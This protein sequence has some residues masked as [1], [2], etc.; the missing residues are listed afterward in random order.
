MKGGGQIPSPRR[1]K[2]KERR[3]IEIKNII[4]HIDSLGLVIVNRDTLEM[5][6]E[7]IRH[8][9]YLEGLKENRGNEGT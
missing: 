5:W 4:E 2:S 7:N 9:G 1:A 8:E 3:M 6:L